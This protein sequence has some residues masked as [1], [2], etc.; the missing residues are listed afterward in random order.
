MTVTDGL[1][2]YLDSGVETFF[3]V[4]RRTE[5]TELLKNNLVISKTPY[6]FF[7]HSHK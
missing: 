2:A 1:N 5:E 6:L 3:L 4:V 7:F